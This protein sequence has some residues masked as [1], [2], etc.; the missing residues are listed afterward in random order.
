[1][2]TQTLYSLLSALI[3][4]G[5]GCILIAEIVTRKLV[6]KSAFDIGTRNPGMNNVMTEFGLKPGLI[7][8]AGDILKTV[9]AMVIAYL[10][11]KDNIGRDALLR[12]GF[13]TVL[14]AQLS[15]LA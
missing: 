3:G 14:G 8:L 10:A 15:V 2:T 5:F 6:H 9:F 4:Y 11:F 7:V 1:M 12:A 13:G